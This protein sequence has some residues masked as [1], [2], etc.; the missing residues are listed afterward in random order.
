MLIVVLKVPKVFI[1]LILKM[2]NIFIARLTAL[3][4]FCV[5]L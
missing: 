1:S 3:E 4:H 5:E 2:W